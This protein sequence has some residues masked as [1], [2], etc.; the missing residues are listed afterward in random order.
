MHK[1][2]NNKVMDKVVAKLRSRGMQ[3]PDSLS[4]DGRWHR[5]PT[6][7]KPHKKNGSYQVRNSSPDSPVV[8]Y[9]NHGTGDSG[10]IS[11]GSAKSL[12]PKEREEI[13][14]RRRADEGEQAKKHAKA[15]KAARRL[16][17]EA[18]AC[19]GHP[20]L[21]RKGVVP[22]PGL[23]CDFNDN[24]LVPLY[25]SEGNMLSFLRIRGDGKKRF[26]SG[27][28]VG[29][30][31]F[32]I[33]NLVTADKVLI[34]EGLATGISL[35]KSTR[36]TVAVVVVFSAGNLLCVAKELCER[37]TEP[38]FIICADNDIRK[39]ASLNT[40]PEAAYAAA[41]A[42]NALVAVAVLGSG[43]KCDF[44]DVHRLEGRERV[45]RLVDA[46]KRPFDMP[47]VDP[48]PR[49]YGYRPNGLYLDLYHED[50]R[51]GNAIYVL[52]QF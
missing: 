39:D 32:T 37:Y 5:C 14:A 33:G 17:E 24:L 15:G 12:H 4:C 23:K 51:L 31:F 7:D 41:H 36:A 30:G 42:I 11:A 25:D 28:K 19:D 6:D 10:T 44:N 47:E 34:C 49:N 20:Y 3:V 2:Y 29:G 22:V 50:T 52:F 13:R 1:L 46:A 26:F 48:L 18:D 45:R 21:T 9:K 16:Y 40:G 27:G 35:H 8:S 43:K 38:Q